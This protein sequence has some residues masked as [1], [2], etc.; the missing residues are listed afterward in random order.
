VRRE[1]IDRARELI[2][3][4]DER[5]AQRLILADLQDRP[6]RAWVHYHDGRLCLAVRGLTNAHRPLTFRE[7]LAWRLA[8][9]MPRP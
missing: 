7:R 6:A 9:R 3:A 1:T 4:G 5:E 2:A 8:R